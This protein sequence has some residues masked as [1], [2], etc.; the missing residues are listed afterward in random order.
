MLSIEKVS[1][2]NL[3]PCALCVGFFEGNLALGFLTT[4]GLVLPS[5]SGICSSKISLTSQVKKKEFLLIGDVEI[6]EQLDGQHEVC[7]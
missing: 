4:R 7:Q 3:A 5:G 2:V 6:W 1:V